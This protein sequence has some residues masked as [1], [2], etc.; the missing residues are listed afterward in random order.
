[1]PHPVR[2]RLYAS[3]CGRNDFYLERIQQAADEMGLDYSLEKVL[4]EDVIEAAGL[5]V[6]CLF[7]Y[8][9]GCKALH[10]EI[11]ADD[12][13]ARC[14]PALEADGELL[15]WDVPADDASLRA[16]LARYR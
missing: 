1:M 15:F 11:T 7:A 6:S 12:P 14:T 10:A 13:S 8:C 9:P 16:A 5:Q 3:I 2:L 4:D